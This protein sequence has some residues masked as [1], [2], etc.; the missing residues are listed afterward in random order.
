MCINNGTTNSEYILIG[1]FALDPP[2]DDQAEEEY[3]KSW[4]YTGDYIDRGTDTSMPR[5]TGIKVEEYPDAALIMYNTNK[6]TNGSLIF[7]YN[8]STCTGASYN[9]SHNRTLFDSGIN[10]TTVREKKLWHMA[11]LFNDSGVS[12]LDYNLTN[13]TTY[14]FNASF[15]AL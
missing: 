12:S 10:L 14:Y 15:L 5:I 4:L 2:G 11:N 7:Y 6:P 3:S 13:D 9:Y 8:D 1:E